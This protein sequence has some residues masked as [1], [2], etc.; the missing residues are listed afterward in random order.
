MAHGNSGLTNG[1]VK[2]LVTDRGFG[3]IRTSDGIEYFFHRSSCPA[4]D[5]L[6]EGT[7]VTFRIGSGL[8]G[9]R[10]EQVSLVD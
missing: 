6:R 3:F 5:E 2:R 1:T 9:P 8:K 7:A 4:Y 10:A